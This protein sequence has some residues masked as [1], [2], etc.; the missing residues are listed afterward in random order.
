MLRWLALDRNLC[1]AA[2]EECFE[3]TL[4]TCWSAIAA[5]KPRQQ[6]SSRMVP[7]PSPTPLIRYSE[8]AGCARWSIGGGEFARCGPLS[9]KSD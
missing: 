9:V 3:V 7:L 6:R 8:C 2:M 5:H 4:F 1:L